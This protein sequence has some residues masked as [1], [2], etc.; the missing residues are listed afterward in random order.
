MT[1]D[2]LDA[3]LNRVEANLSRWRRLVYLTTTLAIAS[4][5]LAIWSL[6]P[7]SELRVAAND[8]SGRVGILT[9]TNLTFWNQAGKPIAR[10][11]FG[12]GGV[13]Q[14][15]LE[16][17]DGSLIEAAAL[18]LPTIR[19]TKGNR[20]ATLS[21]SQFGA[22]L[23]LN[24]DPEFVTL[25]ATE[26]FGSTLRMGS[27]ERGIIGAT[28]GGPQGPPRLQLST[29]DTRSVVVLE[30]DPRHGSTLQLADPS[31]SRTVGTSLK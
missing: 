29:N 30:A 4:L 12:S 22:R 10:F 6:R 3:R 8:G 28:T 9:A 18:A 19:V 20:G 25:Q 17:S 15:T 26:R 5:G 24:D 11:G 2:E 31:A 14:L 1:F 27:S 7:R 13:G 23:T 21:A 16:D